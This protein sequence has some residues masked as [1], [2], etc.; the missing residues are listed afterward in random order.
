V[1]K[2]ERIL[3]IS[4]WVV[5]GLGGALWFFWPRSQVV[6]QVFPDVL[7]GEELATWFTRAKV[8]SVSGAGYKIEIKFQ[9]RY[10]QEKP[11]DERDIHLAYHLMGDHSVLA[12]G[13]IPCRFHPSG[14]LNVE[15]PNPTRVSPRLIRLSLAN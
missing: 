12:Q 5:L 7:L 1:Q 15:I 4:I 8:T 11:V 6:Q 14:A 13:V 2:R 9:E 10:V 3:F